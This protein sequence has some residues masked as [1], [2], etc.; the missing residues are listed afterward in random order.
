MF[1]KF[2]NENAIVSNN[3]NLILHDLNTTYF[4]NE[5]EYN[6]WYQEY[7]DDDSFYLYFIENNEKYYLDCLF[8]NDLMII[9]RNKNIKFYIKYNSIYILNSDI[10]LNIS[11]LGYL[12]YTHKLF[13]PNIKSTNVVLL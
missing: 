6:N 8:D 11:P 9:S 13:I 3:T 5:A 2:I 12:A 4:F 7:N 1:L 10:V